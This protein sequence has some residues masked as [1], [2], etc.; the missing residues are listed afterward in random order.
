MDAPLASVMSLLEE[1]DDWALFLLFALIAVESFGLPVPGETALIACAVL[2]S[3]GS[4]SIVAVIAVAAAAAIIGDNLGY[5]TARE[6]GRP[7]L[8]RHRLT[9]RVADSYLPRGEAFFAEHGGKAVFI[10]RFVA[11]LR[12]T[13][14]WIAGLSRMHW[15]KFLGWNAAGGVV[16]AAAVGLI[17]Y[18]LGDAAATALGRYGLFAAGG[19]I[20]LAGI[21][22]LVARRI[23]KS[24]LDG[25]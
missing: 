6:G 17:A 4:L 12:V 25:D 1:H 22:Y 18:Y 14:A 5:W 9:K 20:L 19:V 7:L 11:V 24:A 13:A 3:Q 15:W 2:A 21:G 16:W 8:E 10:G 23:E